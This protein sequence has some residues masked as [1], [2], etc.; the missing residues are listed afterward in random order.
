M[1]D[2]EPYYSYPYTTQEEAMDCGMAFVDGRPDPH[3]TR[4]EK[5]EDN[6][7][8][9]ALEETS[10]ADDTLRQLTEQITQ[11]HLAGKFLVK[12][13]TPIKRISDRQE[14]A[15]IEVYKHSYS[16]GREKEASRTWELRGGFKDISEHCDALLSWLRS[17]SKDERGKAPPF[18]RPY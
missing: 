5:R 17:A 7:L 12:D 14:R 8:A 3:K 13:I 10:A 16:E 9:I 18:K 2:D 15:L 1:G 6:I 11:M 4:R